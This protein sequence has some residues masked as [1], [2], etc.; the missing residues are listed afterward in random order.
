MLRSILFCAVLFSGV[1]EGA[2]LRFSGVL[3]NSG[4]G[5]QT[6]VSFFGRQ[7]A[8]MGPVVDEAM[9]LW[10]RGG[11]NPLIRYSLDGRP[12]DQFELPA[13]SDRNDQ[14][15]LAGKLLVIRVNRVVY[16]LPIDAKTGQSLEEKL[17]DVGILSSSSFA[18]RVA[19]YQRQQQAVSWLDPA[20]GKLEVAFP[21]DSGLQGLQGLQALH[22]EEDGTI[23]AF[24]SGQ[25]QAW[26]N[27]ELVDGYPKEFRG[28]RPQKI[29]QF[30]YSHGWHG[31]IHRMNDRFE[32]EPGVVLGGASGSFIGYLPQSV[33]LTNGR[34]LVHVRDNTYAA[35]GTRGIVQLLEWNEADVR[36]EVARRIGALPELSGIAIDKN[37]NVWTPSGSWRWSDSCEV[38]CTIGDRE[39]DVHAQP[40]MLDGTQL[41][42]LKKHYSYVQLIHGPL[43]DEHGW[44]HFESKS[45]SDLELPAS[46]SGAAAIPGDRGLSLLVVD[47]DGNAFQLGITASGEPRGKPSAVNLPGLEDCTSLAW[48]DGQLLAGTKQGVIVF[49]REVEGWK[50]TQRLCENDGR[51]F[52][53]SDGKRLVVS[54]P[55][56]GVVTVFDSL[57]NRIAEYN[58]L[59]CPE[60]VAISGDRLVVYEAGKQRIVKLEVVQSDRPI[61]DKLPAVR[62]LE[63]ESVKSEELHAEVDFQDWSR[64][65]GIPLEVAVTPNTSGLAVSFRTGADPA[66]ELQ[67]G[68]TNSQNSFF[69]KIAASEW[70]E[71]QVSLQLPGDWP[72]LRLAVAVQLA[73]QRE[74]FGFLDQLPIHASFNHDPSQWA[75]FNLENYREL[76]EA[77]RE[78]IRIVFEQPTDGKATVVIEDENGHRVRNLASGK[79]FSAG[80]HTLVWDGLDEAGKLVA[81]GHYRWRGVTH[82]GVTPE[83][84]MHFANGGESTTAS[85]GPNH[86]TFHHAATNGKLM[87]FAAP[88]TEGGWALV[89]LDE[90]GNFVQGYEHLHGYGIQHDAIA[91]DERYL[92]CAQDG[93]TWG[94]TKGVDLASDDWTANWTMTVVRYD[95]A[96]GRLVE[97]PGKQRGLEIDVME[98]GPGSAHADLEEF[99]LGGLAVYD[100]KLYVGS[101]DEQAVLVL[102]AETGKRIG[103]IP[104]KGVRH[105]AAGDGVFAVTD[106]GVIRLSDG[107]RLIE[108]NA[109]QLSGLTIAANNDILVSDRDSHQIRRYT[110]DGK[111]IGEIGSPGGP[112]KGAYEPERMVNPAGLAFGPDGKLWVTEKRWNPKRI[113]AWDL[114]ETAAK[115]VYEKF[116]MPH[117]GGDGSG[118]DPENPKRWIGL[119]CFW[120]VDIEQG[121]ARPT[122]ILSLAEGHFGN[123]EPH[124]YLFFR[125]AGRTFVCTRGKIALLS[126]VLPDGTLHDIAAVAGTHHFGY[127]CQWDPP[128]SYIDAFYAKWPEKRAQEKPGR[129][130]NGKPWSQRGM[131]VLWVDRNGDGEPQQEEFN[132]CGDDIAF[133]GGAWGHL[134]SSLTLYVPV[135][136]DDQVKIAAI[137]P[138]GFLA[139][140]VPDYPT[141]D[142]AIAEATPIAL[143]AGYKRSGVSTVRDRFGRFLFNSDPEMNAYAIKSNTQVDLQSSKSTLSGQHLW[144]YPNQWSDVHGSHKAPLPEPGV[145]Q[146]V[147]AFLGCAPFDDCSDVVFMN[148]NHGRCFLMT[149]DGLYLDEC[150]VDVRVSYLRNEY[151]LGGEIFGGTFGRSLPDGKYYVQIGHGPYR[152]YELSGLTQA[153][154][155]SGSL[156][157][158]PQQL[159]AA[160]Q[161]QLRQ[162]A[163]KQVA[164][165]ATV[166]GTI[167]W[168]RNGQFR[169]EVDV[170]LEAERLLLEY[171]VEDSSPWKN[172]GRDWT[173]LFATGDS[174]DFQ[175]ATNPDA[176][177]K[178]RSPVPGDKRLLIAPL[179][180][181]PIAVLYEHRKPSGVNP[182]EFTSPWR[183]EKV[184]NVQQLSEARIDVET[185]SRGYIARVEVPLKSLGL[186]VQPGVNYRADFGATY[187]DVEGTETNLR[188][189]WSNNSTGLVDD[190]PGEIMLSPVLWGEVT[191][192]ELGDP[193]A[194][195]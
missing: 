111:L 3:G 40:V 113:L 39:P 149:T 13:Q 62:T 49:Q 7:A 129:K 42:L 126:E 116:G 50:Q 41:C 34:G 94:G 12:L 192:R 71:G 32:P 155:I 79:S 19:V 187:G 18:G 138:R 61:P 73:T 159:A 136:V 119:G 154:R 171:R 175:F 23:F 139:N 168:D 81:P 144:E 96:S 11:T 76:V 161:Q 87:F 164:Q 105:L 124:G 44:S 131:G 16:T 163:K 28:E 118:F 85:W 170:R 186:S 190:I 156:D 169:A 21:V 95:I 57:K 92:Y 33:D 172:Q 121:S 193:A 125:E 189:Y 183:A 122:H 86:S 195:E 25:V 59:Q 2:E 56:K 158:T 9:T 153:Q 157:I 167:R 46:V 27:G 182:I 69:V 82:P 150:F 180:G 30:W 145:M 26:R 127:G 112:Y 160:E 72:D 142:E 146:G 176:D 36:F 10:E 29:G 80:R 151:R 58:E 103:S 37:G 64:P 143:T 115:V 38:P 67:L 93:F 63:A 184:D 14:L 5:D 132:F 91:A 77:R 140:G 70:N 102:D 191:F 78:E 128:Q 15:T 173:K 47:R 120:E 88:V 137:T 174:V 130:G 178:R 133:A 148:G 68:V 123:Y 6:L 54:S 43:I 20:T 22:V 134:Q 52:V 8:G 141:L 48:L 53:Q 65:G 89:A 97:F 98:V 17:S 83:Y 1:A 60:H 84:K 106:R 162:V 35:S 45:V 165:Q 24:G 104:V 101:R 179:D 31:T 66:P 90:D 74:R 177:P 114:S 55:A 185:N 107:K 99:N 51:V 188:S 108:A 100:G 75:P 181:K 152:I 109:R 135:E 194:E 166:P 147:M 110:E 4:Y 117:Y